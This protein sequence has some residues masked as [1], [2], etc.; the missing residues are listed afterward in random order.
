MLVRGWKVSTALLVPQDCV[1]PCDSL[2]IGETKTIAKTCIFLTN[3]TRQGLDGTGR[4]LVL[5][6][7]GVD[8]RGQQILDV[9]LRIRKHQF[10]SRKRGHGGHLDVCIHL[11]HHALREVQLFHCIGRCE[12]SVN[13]REGLGQF[14]QKSIV[15]IYLFRSKSAHRV[16]KLEL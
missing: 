13:L 3:T 5:D 16:M 8:I 4:H 12:I 6:K 14:V 2:W 9:L 7:S 10:H 1:M 15:T 11:L